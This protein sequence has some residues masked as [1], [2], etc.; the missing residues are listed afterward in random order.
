MTTVGN[1]FTLVGN[2]QLAAKR[3][4]EMNFVEE[5]C[6]VANQNTFQDAAI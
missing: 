1:F 6:A 2:N 3:R 4:Q 5:I